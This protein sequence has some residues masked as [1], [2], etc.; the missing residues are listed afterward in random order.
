[1]RLAAPLAA[2]ATLL[3][4]AV[5]G[6]PLFPLPLPLPS[7]GGTGAQVAASGG[8]LVPGAGLR[9]KGLRSSPGEGPT[10]VFCQ[11]GDPPP[12]PPPCSISPPPQMR[13]QLHGWVFRALQIQPCQLPWQ[14][15]CPLHPSSLS[16]AVQNA[17]LVP[18]R[19][20]AAVSLGL[21][22]TAL[23]LSTWATPA[24][25]SRLGPTSASSETLSHLPE[26][27]VSPAFIAQASALILSLF[28]G[29]GA[30]QSQGA[31]LLHF[32]VPSTGWPQGASATEL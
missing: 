12:S 18:D 31:G 17:R 16:S 22:S 32:R 20:R 29:L 3:G 21:K 28:V 1:M 15:P 25:P 5:V 26:E 13:S 10:P 11:Q 9:G 27:L 24:P 19:S 2:R 23:S 8:G 4:W 14:Y 30:P 6:G 7:G